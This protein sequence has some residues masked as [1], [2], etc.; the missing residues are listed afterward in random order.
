MIWSNYFVVCSFMIK[1]KAI[2]P[3]IPH[4]TNPIVRPNAC[5][6]S[7]M[8]NGPIISP[9]SLKDPAIPTVCPKAPFFAKELTSVSVLVHTIPTPIPETIDMR[10]STIPLTNGIRITLIA[11]SMRPILIVIKGFF[12]QRLFQQLVVSIYNLEQQRTLQFLR[13]MVYIISLLS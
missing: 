12:Y 1:P 8:S 2:N 7:P 3:K 13:G 4:A 11:E 5:D 10:I 6:S 9:N